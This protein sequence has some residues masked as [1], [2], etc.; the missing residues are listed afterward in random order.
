MPEFLEKLP[1]T[2]PLSRVRRNHGLEHATIHLLS[3]ANPRRSLA[4]YSDASG[5]WLVGNVTTPELR[6]AA[7]TA[8]ARMKAGE[9]GLAVHPNC[10]TNF[11]VSGTVAG[12]AGAAA[13]LG[14]SNRWSDRFDRM[15][16]AV[17]LATLGLIAAQPLGFHIQRNYTTSGVPGSLEIVD[18]YAVER[19]GI[20]THRV[21]TKG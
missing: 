8:L 15:M 19:G 13:M 21:L 11:L 3:H 1:P 5:F 14:V 6:Q 20:P 12:L 16:V 18:I 17:M 2:S 9:R 7:E 10:G 4:G